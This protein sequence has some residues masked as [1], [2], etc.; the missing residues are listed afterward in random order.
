MLAITSVCISR[1]M[2]S[3]RTLTA[4]LVSDPALVFNNTEMG[5]V[6]WRKGR[7]PGDIIVDVPDRTSP[8]IIDISRGASRDAGSA[9]DSG[10]MDKYWEG[11]D[12]DKGSIDEAK[13]R[14]LGSPV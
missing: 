4:E 1:M 2:L 11:L 3:I 5:R 10:S 12:S 8:D 13:I 14:R 7:N 6:C 9:R